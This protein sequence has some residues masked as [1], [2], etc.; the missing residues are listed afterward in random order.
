[1]VIFMSSISTNLYDSNEA[2]VMARRARALGLDVQSALYLV[3]RGKADD[4]MKQV[5]IELGINKSLSDNNLSFDSFVK[6]SDS[7]NNFLFQ[8]EDGNLYNL[9]YDTN[10]VSS[11]SVEEFAEENGLINEDVGKA[12]DVV[13][14]GQNNAEF[15]NYVFDG[16]GIGTTNDGRADTTKVALG[17]QTWR[18]IK[19]VQQEVNQKTWGSGASDE[20]S[21]VSNRAFSNIFKHR[22]QWLT[23]TQ[24]TELQK[25]KSYEEYL[26]LIAEFAVKDMDESGKAEY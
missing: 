10:K 19:F 3:S 17:N 13:S 8:G 25:V 21:V 23:A 18:N 22:N 20:V 4:A 2:T 7:D 26:E 24:K 16:S 11:Q 15:I 9:N 6:S 14:F 1:M 12:Y 5:G